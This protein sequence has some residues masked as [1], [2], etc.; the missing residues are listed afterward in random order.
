MA[1]VRGRSRGTNGPWREY[2]HESADETW[3]KGTWYA[4]HGDDYPGVATVHQPYQ[5]DP[6]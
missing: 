2:L 6:V 1:V 5:K 3:Q 4:R